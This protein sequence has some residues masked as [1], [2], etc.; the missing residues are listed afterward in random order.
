MSEAGRRTI[1]GYKTSIP[2]LPMSAN[3]K[4]LAKCLEF[5]CQGRTGQLNPHTFMN[6]INSFHK[7][8][9]FICIPVEIGSDSSSARNKDILPHSP[10]SGLLGLNTDGNIWPAQSQSR[11]NIVITQRQ[12]GFRTDYGNCRI[13]SQRKVKTRG[14]HRE[15]L[16]VCDLKKQ[17]WT[18]ILMNEN[19]ARR[20]QQPNAA[21]MVGW[22]YLTLAILLGVEQW[23][24]GQMFSFGN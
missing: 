19:L 24:K 14:S 2:P 23:W 17:R 18:V 5:L 12:G 8:K 3:D 22:R 10:L 6:K 7:H 9:S 13:K 15:K 21:F 4:Y 11:H 16:C 20:W 1:E